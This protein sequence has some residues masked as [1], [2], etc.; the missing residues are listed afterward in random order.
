MDGRV[1]VQDGIEYS[2]PPKSMIIN[3]ILKKV[4]NGH[5]SIPLTNEKYEIPRN[6]IRFFDSLEKRG[7]DLH[8]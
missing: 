7:I 3:A 4:Y 2:E 1:W 6:L 5:S 8:E